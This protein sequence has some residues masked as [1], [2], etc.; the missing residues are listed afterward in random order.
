MA[1]ICDFCSNAPA[2]WVYPARDFEVYE[3]RSLKG[4]SA[5]AWA[6][7]DLC[8]VYIERGDLDGLTNRVLNT[9]FDSSPI[10]GGFSKLEKDMMKLDVLEMTKKF[11][12][13]RT[14]FE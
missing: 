5:G 3:T 14:S 2:P 13:N 4:M 12:A 11:F 6:A 7:C 10:V 9:L 8:R 1:D